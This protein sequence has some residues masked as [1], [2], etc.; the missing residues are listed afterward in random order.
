MILWRW[1]IPFIARWFLQLHVFPFKGFDFALDG[2]NWLDQQIF[3]GFSW[4][5]GI[6]WMFAR[7]NVKLMR[8]WWG[9]EVLTSFR[10]L[11]EVSTGSFKLFTTDTTDDCWTDRWFSFDFGQGF[12]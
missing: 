4:F 6:L 1:L 2:R 3:Q 9:K 12:R 11:F 8:L 5:G 10:G 7:W